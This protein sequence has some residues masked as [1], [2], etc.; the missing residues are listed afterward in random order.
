M[1][2]TILVREK[3]FAIRLINNNLLQT[4]VHQFPT[5]ANKALKLKDASF[6]TSLFTRLEREDN[7]HIYL[8]ATEV[9]IAYNDKNINKQIV[10][11]SKRNANLRNGWG[12]QD[13]ATLL[14]ANN[15]K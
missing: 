6:I 9:L 5:F 11:V 3:P 2:D 4:N 14:K 15:I 1:L 13:F 10:E 12:G 7:P 8:K